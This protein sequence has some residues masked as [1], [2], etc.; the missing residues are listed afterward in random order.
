MFSC[1]C[2]SHSPGITVS[3]EASTYWT[4][5]GYDERGLA[6]PTLWMWLPNTTM[7]TLCFS[8]LLVPVHTVPAWMTFSPGGAFCGRQLR[9]TGTVLGAPPLTETIRIVPAES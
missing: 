7:S 6:G 1:E 8:V 4:W 3:C 5:R 9:S 2:A